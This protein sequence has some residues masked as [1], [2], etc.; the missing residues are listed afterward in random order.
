[1]C[2]RVVQHRELITYARELGINL[3]GQVP[4]AP[5]IT[6]A[7]QARTCS[8]SGVIRRLEKVVWGFSAGASSRIGRKIGKLHGS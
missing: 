1:M 4:N 6:M 7:H 3:S 5:P 8:C 2:G